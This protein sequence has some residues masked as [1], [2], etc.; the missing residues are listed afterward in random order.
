MTSYKKPKEHSVIA[1]V[2]REHFFTS[3]KLLMDS[4]EVDNFGCNAKI[5][6]ELR[7]MKISKL[8]AR[9][10]ELKFSYNLTIKLSILQG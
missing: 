1:V 9:K 2:N 3:Q 7:C 5:Y 10:I 8:N 4:K 6:E